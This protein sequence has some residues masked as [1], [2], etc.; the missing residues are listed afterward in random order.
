[1]QVGHQE[2]QNQKE[3]HDPGCLRPTDNVKSDRQADGSHDGSGRHHTRGYSR[4]DKRSD[5]DECREWLQYEDDT[6]GS[7]DTLAAAKVQLGRE[8]VSQ[9]GEQPARDGKGDGNRQV[10][11]K[12]RRD[13]CGDG[14]FS[15]VQQIDADSPVSAQDAPGIGRSQ[16]ATAVFP[17]IDATKPPDKERRPRHAANSVAQE[18][19]DDKGKDVHDLR[20]RTC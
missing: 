17:Q 14:T 19:P 2:C 18:A 4:G 3:A 11:T 6:G 10:S 5:G 15:E 16:I 7:G 8:D 9:Y 1:M 20:L 12:A 13:A